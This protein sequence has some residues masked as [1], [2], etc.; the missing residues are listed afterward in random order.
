MGADESTLMMDYRAMI[1]AKIDYGAVAYATASRSL[2][3]AIDTIHNRGLRLVTGAFCTSPINSLYC[4]AAEPPLELRREQLSLAYAASIFN[5]PENLNYAAITKA[6]NKELYHGAGPKAPF[7]IRIKQLLEL[8]RINPRNL[9]PISKNIVPPWTMTKPTVDLSLTNMSKS[10]TPPNVLNTLSSQRIASYEHYTVIYT[11]ASKSAD[12][13]GTGIVFPDKTV[14]HR[15]ACINSPLTAELT[16][17]KGALAEISTRPESRFLICTD[18]LAAVKGLTQSPPQTALNQQIQDLVH[19][20][21]VNGKSL[22]I[23][24]IPSHIGIPGNDQADEAAKECAQNPTATT[25]HHYYK[26]DLQNHL[27]ASRHRSGQPYK[28][29]NKEN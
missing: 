24:W 14:A 11:D 2:L 4:A 22:T 6:P 20:L 13:V 3:K 8:H 10:G 18:S 17:I 28:A 16:A 9:I 23:L 29:T 26:E 19:C 7:N 1:R 25:N 15:L 27:K 5:N 12:G 21:A